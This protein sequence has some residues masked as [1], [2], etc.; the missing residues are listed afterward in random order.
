MFRLSNGLFGVMTARIDEIARLGWLEYERHCHLYT[1]RR[2]QDYAKALEGTKPHPKGCW[3]QTQSFSWCKRQPDGT[4][5]V[6][7]ILRAFYQLDVRKN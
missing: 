3:I 6:Y 5:E 7:T 1:D 4:M 2:V